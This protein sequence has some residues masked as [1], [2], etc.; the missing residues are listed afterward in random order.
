MERV[1]AMRG[2]GWRL[3]PV[4]ANG[5]LA[6]ATYAPD[7]ATG[8]VR[9]HSLQVFTVTDGLVRRCVTFADPAVFDLFSLPVS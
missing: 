8:G 9:A 4:G 7:T 2:P 1:F 5:S 6:L 3:L